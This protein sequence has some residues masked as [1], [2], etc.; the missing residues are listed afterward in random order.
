MNETEVNQIENKLTYQKAGI[1]RWKIVEKAAAISID[2]LEI[3][4]NIDGFEHKFCLSMLHRVELRKDISQKQFKIL[5][6][7]FER[8][9]RD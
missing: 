9:S 4:G 8:L 2:V 7:I 1:L 6:D 5:M 3:K